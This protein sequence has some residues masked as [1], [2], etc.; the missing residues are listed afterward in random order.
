MKLLNVLLLLFLPCGSIFA[1]EID[2]ERARKEAIVRA[3]Q[4]RLDRE[5]AEFEA[6][7]AAKDSL[8]KK[9]QETRSKFSAL[10]VKYAGDAQLVAEIDNKEKLAIKAAK[11][12]SKKQL[13]KKTSEISGLQSTERDRESLKAELAEIF[14]ESKVKASHTKNGYN[15]I[16]FGYYSQKLT[17]KTDGPFPSIFDEDYKKSMNMKGLEVSYLH[18]I[19]VSKKI[20][21][22]VEIGGRIQFNIY[23]NKD[24]YVVDGQRYDDVLRITNLSLAVPVNI[25][26][27]HTFTNGFYVAPYFGVNL[28]V[29]MTGKW[30]YD[31]SDYSEYYNIFKADDN[32]EHAFYGSDVDPCKR[33][34]YGCQLGLNFGFKALNIGIGYYMESPLYNS[35]LLYEDDR[36]Y[37]V[38]YKMNNVSLTLGINF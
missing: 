5:R 15:R 24:S 20:P 12:D 32:D 35:Q 11:E 27:K 3:A 19:S 21:L 26:Y 30:D 31:G 34:Q 25:T 13:T 6:K 10:R 7:K 8:D 22:F 16:S 18:G 14:D 4:E 36:L 17:C 29:N 33:L 1:Q 23:K 28:R 2:E 38:K 37:D 9:I